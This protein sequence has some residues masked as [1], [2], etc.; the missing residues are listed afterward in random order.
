MK[1]FEFDSHLFV[2]HAPDVRGGDGAEGHG[3]VGR[4]RVDPARCCCCS[5][6]KGGFE[7][8]SLASHESGI[9]ARR[10]KGALF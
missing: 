10:A 4:R 9:D 5:E 6:S 3:K 8:V 1:I 2:E 7:L